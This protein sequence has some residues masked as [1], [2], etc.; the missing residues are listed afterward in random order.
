V[1]ADRGQAGEWN[2]VGSASIRVILVLALVTSTAWCQHSDT[3]RIASDTHVPTASL[4]DAPSSETADK[5]EILRAF[6]DAVRAPATVPTSDLHDAPIAFTNVYLKER[7]APKEPTNIFEKYLSPA[8]VKQSRTYHPSTGGSFMSR[9]TYAASSIVITRDETGR[10]KLNTSYLLAVLS[11]AAAH[12]ANCPYCKRSVSQ[13]FGDFGSTVGN[14]AGVNL[15]HEFEPGIRGLVKNHEP[16]F[17][18]KIE[19]RIRS[20]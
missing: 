1:R 17:I 8:A 5:T 6:E 14:D 9:A 18:Y 13:P 12:S 16:R 19:D 15:F 3:L 10:K 2:M 4:P 11:S 20:R 7:S